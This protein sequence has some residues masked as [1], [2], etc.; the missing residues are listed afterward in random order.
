MDAAEKL[1][2]HGITLAKNNKLLTI[3]HKQ[4]FTS[5]VNNMPARLFTTQS[6]HISSD[7]KKIEHM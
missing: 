2:F 5:L 3:N 7:H 6:S 4:F 1:I